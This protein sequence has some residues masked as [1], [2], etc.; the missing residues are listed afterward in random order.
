[1][2]KGLLITVVAA[3]LLAL[4]VPV[5]QAL[6]DSQKT[7]L[8][9]LYRQ[10]H[11]LRL[12]ILEKQVEAGLVDPE[13]AEFFREKMEQRW[14]YRQERMA[15]GEYRFGLRQ[16]GRGLGRRGGG[17]GNCPQNTNEPEL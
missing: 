1:M 5:A 9:S 7:E 8:E 12:Q 15:E 2:K 16:G 17:C 13:Q 4:A 3:L 11:A 6:T 14:Q 10:E